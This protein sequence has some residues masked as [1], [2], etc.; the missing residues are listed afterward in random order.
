MRLA[1][2]GLGTTGSHIARQLIQAPVTELSLYDI[3]RR[4]LERVVPAV[5]AVAHDVEVVTGQP[6]PADPAD[7]VVLAGPVGTHAKPAA[8][9]VAAGSHIVSISDDPAEVTQLLALDRSARDRQ[10][11][12]VVGAGFAPGLSCLL[13]RF[14]ADCL[15]S[16]EVINVYKAGTG[17]PACARQHHRALRSDGHDWVEGGWVLRRGGSGRDLAWFPEPYGARDCYRGALSSPVLLQ[18]VFPNAQRISA[19]MSATRRDRLTS[20]MPMLRRPHDDGGPGGLRVEVRG[21]SGRAVETIILGAIDHP[22]VAGGTVAAVTALAAGAGRAPQ[23]ANGIAAWPEPKELLG[24]LRRKGIRVASFDG[25]LDV[26]AVAPR[27]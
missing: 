16:V 18:R 14:A 8:S 1:L 12:L 6:D 5:R 22:A 15:D 19:R 11:A 9:M 2:V 13:A 7:V 3:D 24:S 21:R 26:M 20:R 10:R 25:Q 4:R 23:G 17:G 27:R